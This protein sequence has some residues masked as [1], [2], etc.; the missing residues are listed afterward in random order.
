[1]PLLEG[2]T[3]DEYMMKAPVKKRKVS[4]ARTIFVFGS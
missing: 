4:A 2:V 1:M 3:K